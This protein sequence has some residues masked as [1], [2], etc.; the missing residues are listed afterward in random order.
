MAH[1]CVNADPSY[2][3]C[4]IRPR[5]VVPH[6]FWP[7]F[8][9]SSV[10]GVL[11][12][13]CLA[14]S[15]INHELDPRSDLAVFQRIEFGPPKAEIQFDSWRRDQFKGWKLHKL[16]AFLLFCLG[17]T[18]QG[19]APSRPPTAVPVHDL[20]GARHLEIQGFIASANTAPTA[21]KA[22]LQLAT[23]LIARSEFTAGQKRGPD[24]D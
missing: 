3:T 19:L 15:V 5:S 17:Q 18:C 8:R 21:H 4:A 13:R 23:E 11:H 22:S 24:R 2:G 12:H 9:W 7:R 16:P 20:A 6:R 1:E 10:R 14:Q